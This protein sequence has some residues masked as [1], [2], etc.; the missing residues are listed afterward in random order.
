MVATRGRKSPRDLPT[1]DIGRIGLAV[2]RSQPR[3]VYA[4]LET[5][6]TEVYRSDDYGASWTKTGTYFQYPVVHGPDPR[7]SK[8]SRSHLRAWRSDLCVGGWRSDEHARSRQSAH[9]DYH[10]MWIDPTDRDH[11]VVGNDGGVYITLRS[12]ADDGLRQQSADRAVLRDRY[13][14]IA[15]RS[16]TCTADCR[17]TTAGRARARRAIAR[18][19][20][21]ATGT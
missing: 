1:R 18:E 3:T 5:N 7:R 12:R 15:C 21:T 20:R 6:T 11:F 4:T 8:Q 14:T 2:S 16:T 19:S 17:T 10:A 9:V 13:S